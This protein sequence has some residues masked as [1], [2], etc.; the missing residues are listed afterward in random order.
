MMCFDFPGYEQMALV[1]VGDLLELDETLAPMYSDSVPDLQDKA[2]DLQKL[3]V[4]Y[5]PAA[6][7][8][9]TP[10]E[11]SDMEIEQDTPQA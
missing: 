6:P 2:K 5:I 3:L 8:S 9:P 4:Q 7:P 11:E 1:E 10:P